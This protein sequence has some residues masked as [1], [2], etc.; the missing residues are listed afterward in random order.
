MERGGGANNKFLI[1]LLRKEGI[2][3]GKKEEMFVF[4]KCF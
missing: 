1:S 2:Y 3:N 4:T